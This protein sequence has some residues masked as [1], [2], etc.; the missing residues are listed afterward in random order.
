VHRERTTIR[1]YAPDL[2]GDEMLIRL[3]RHYVLWSI[4]SLSLPAA[5]AFAFTG[6]AYGALEGLLWG[7][8]VRVFLTQHAT[9]ALNSFAHVFGTQRFDM[10]EGSRNNW[11]LGIVLGGEGWHNNHHAFPGSAVTGLHWWEV[12]PCGWLILLFERLNWAK[13]VRR[14]SQE[15]VT[16]R[17]RL[18]GGM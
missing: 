14:P 7:G 16:S 8:F 12:D 11:V 10:A 18:H 15:Q 5:L 13:K 6:T 17:T 2:L 4:V 9:F 3:S 1:K